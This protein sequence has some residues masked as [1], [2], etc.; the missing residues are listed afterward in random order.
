MTEDIKALIKS[1]Y[2]ELTGNNSKETKLAEFDRLLDVLDILRVQCPWDAKQTNDSLRSNTVEEVF[3]LA[4]ALIKN[5]S[6]NIRKELGDVLL[7][8]LF[9]SKIGSEKGD[10]DIADVCRSLT[11][12]LVFRHPH[13]FGD[14]EADNAE[15]VAANWEQIKLKEKDGNHTVLGGV[16]DALPALIKANRI[17][18]KVRNV[19]F[20]WEDPSQVWDKVEEERQEVLTEIK[21]GDKD[22]L[23][24]EFGDLLFA[25]INAARLYGVNPENAL[26][27][28]N[29]KF[30]RRFNFLEAEVKR[31]G[32]SLKDMSLEEMDA[33]WDKAKLSE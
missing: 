23:E 19:G 31:L 15:K 3:E 17:Q 21:S 22:R 25:V 7:H 29:R 2:P 20:D 10:F 5:D 32:M 14:T 4:D 30:I 24:Q 8:V 16:P 11:D 18:E 26:E 6:R 33:I 27:R 9:Y 1:K 12:K 13:V 28:T